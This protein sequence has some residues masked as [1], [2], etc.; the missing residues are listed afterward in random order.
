M[1]AKKK[2]KLGRAKQVRA[3]A[4]KL[5][6]FSPLELAHAA[7]AVYPA[8][9]KNVRRTL[10]DLVKTGEIIKTGPARYRYVP[11]KAPTAGVQ[12]KIFRAMAAKRNFSFAE[13]ALLTDADESYVGLLTKKLSAAGY[14]CAAGKKDRRRRFRVAS[15]DKFHL[16]FIKENNFERICGSIRQK[17]VA[18]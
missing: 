8:E 12:S 3:A 11:G 17:I 13:I 1:T 18:K 9:N 10:Y 15:A 14:L 4:A 2:Y 6:A 7:N 16:D 5:V